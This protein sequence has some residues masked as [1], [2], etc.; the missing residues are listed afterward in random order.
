MSHWCSASDLL[1]IGLANE[2]SQQEEISG[3]FFMSASLLS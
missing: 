1:L 2:R 3:D